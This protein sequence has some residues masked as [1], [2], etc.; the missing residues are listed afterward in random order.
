MTTRHIEKLNFGKSVIE[1]MTNPLYGLL[2][3]LPLPGWELS[4]Q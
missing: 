2:R 1:L 4:E 3:A